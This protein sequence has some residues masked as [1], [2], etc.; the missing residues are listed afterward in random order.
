[1]PVKLVTGLL[2]GLGGSATGGDAPVVPDSPAAW[3]LA[4]WTR[5]RMAQG[6]TVQEAPPAAPVLSSQ[7][8]AAPDVAPLA[9]AA[10]GAPVSQTAAAVPVVLA[11]VSVGRD[12]VGVATFG[13]RVYVANQ[14]DKTVSVIDTA[15]DTVVAT[16]PVAGSATGVAVNA[17]GSRVYVTL[18]GAAKVA[19]INTA[20]N[21]VVSTIS[22]GAGPEAVAVSPT[23]SRAYVS[24]TGGRRCR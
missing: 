16:V 11:P 24:N 23:G 22:T 8:L 13:S 19:V 10:L 3:A 17:D 7:K 5:S 15:S 12:P 6:K 9:A 18:K 14:F 2:A 1:M 20:S 4:A 21:A